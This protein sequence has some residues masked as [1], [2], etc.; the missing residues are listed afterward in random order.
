VKLHSYSFAV[1]LAQKGGVV[2]GK[3]WGHLV[4]ENEVAIVI[5]PGIWRMG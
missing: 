1:N 5:F 4:P 2:Q 3:V